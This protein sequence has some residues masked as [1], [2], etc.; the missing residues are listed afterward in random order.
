MLCTCPTADEGLS[1]T[2]E[3]IGYIVFF[4]MSHTPRS[5]SC[6]Y[7]CH[8]I[9][10]M[11]YQQQIP[12]RVC[13]IQF[14][15][16][17]NTATILRNDEFQTNKFKTTYI[18]ILQHWIDMAYISIE[19]LY[20]SILNIVQVENKGAILAYVPSVRTRCKTPWLTL[21]VIGNMSIT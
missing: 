8:F 15:Y 16:S 6:I 14:N 9:A 17:S 20:V 18:I 21:H 2:E 10:C 4:I 19:S 3:F 7:V 5:H 11:P 13:V 1:Q 12:Q